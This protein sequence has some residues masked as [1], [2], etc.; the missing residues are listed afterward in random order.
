MQHK[1][2]DSIKLRLGNDR[3]IFLINYYVA[4]AGLLSWQANK[5]VWWQVRQWS[6][7]TDDCS[8]SL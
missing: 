8:R 2:Q 6:Y 7:L 1:F 4:V 5:I 3:T